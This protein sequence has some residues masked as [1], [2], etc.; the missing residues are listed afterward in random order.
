MTRVYQVL[1]GKA[2]SMREV[3]LYF[4]R[5]SVHMAIK[6]L[7]YAWS[8]MLQSKT[9]QLPIIDRL[10][11]N[12]DFNQVF[13]SIR[14]G[15]RTELLRHARKA[16]M[17]CMEDHAGLMHK[18]GAVRCK[19]FEQE[20]DPKKKWT[21]EEKWK[22]FEDGRENL[23]KAYLPEGFESKF[24]DAW[25]GVQEGVKCVATTGWTDQVPN[26]ASCFLVNMEKNGVLAKEE[27][28]SWQPSEQSSRIT[29]RLQPLN[30][31][32]HNHLFGLI[33]VLYAYFTPVFAHDVEVRCL[34]GLFGS[35]NN[36]FC[37]PGH[38]CERNTIEDASAIVAIL[39]VFVLVSSKDRFGCR[40]SS[41]QQQ[42][43][44][45]QQQR[46]LNWVQVT[47]CNIAEPVPLSEFF[48]RQ[49]Q[50]CDFCGRKSFEERMEE[51]LF[52]DFMHEETRLALQSHL[53]RQ[54][55]RFCGSLDKLELPVY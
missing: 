36:S 30:P 34:S 19:D 49:Q 47:C 25:R 37:R 48:L 12:S 39:Q 41:Q 54:A 13:E 50:P 21:L 26:L 27:R 31:N 32:C 7:E 46:L 3:S 43:Q 15:F 14:R 53:E 42:Q 20:R 2:A 10:S 45:Q 33:A 22:E 35:P 17:S 6:C 8:N 29:D 40:Q 55:R 44:Q 38:V 18:L 9:T 28:A 16:Y 4:V 51:E 1:K 5:K 24:P 23:L 52:K 11:G